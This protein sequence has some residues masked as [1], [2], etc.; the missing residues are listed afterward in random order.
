MKR[1]DNFEKW[2]DGMF[3]KLGNEDRYFHPNFF[4][5]YPEVKRVEIIK[6]ML[7]AQSKDNILEIGCG[8]GHIIKNIRRGQITGIDLSES[9]LRVAKNRLRGMNNVRL[10]KAN[11]EDL[12]FLNEKFDKIICTEVLEHVENPSKVISEI[13]KVSHRKTSIILTIPNEKLINSFKNFFIKLGLFNLLFKGIPKKMDDEWHLHSFDLRLLK[14][15]IRNKLKIV[16]IKASPFS[17]V[18]VR[19]LVECR[20][21]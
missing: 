5:R 6:K 9:A 10:L 1:Y 12:A 15:I 8:A 13:L 14:K 18:P 7:K 20:V 16:Q 11:A 21:L 2:N 19:Y 3:K 17:I 4:V